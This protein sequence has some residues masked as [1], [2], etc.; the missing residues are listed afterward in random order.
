MNVLIVDDELSAIE[1]VR[2]GIQWGMIGI[3]NVFTAMNVQE[4]TRQF[5]DVPIDILLSDIEMPMGTGLE[6]L[7]W[8]NAHHPHVKCIFMT[9]HADFRF[10]QEAMQLGSVNYILKPLNFDKMQ[11]VLKETKDNILADRI[12]NEN[13]NSWIQNKKSVVKQFWKD[14]FL[15]EIS[16]NKDSLTNYFR[17]KRLEINLENAYLPI[18]IVTKKFTESVTKEDQKLLHY[19][20]RNITEEIFVIPGVAEEV[21]PFSE[22]TLLVMLEMD[23]SQDEHRLY[24]QINDCCR[25]LSDTAAKYIKEIICCY[26]GDKDTIYEMPSIIEALQERDFNNVIHES[27]VF[28]LKQERRTHSSAQSEFPIAQWREWIRQGRYNQVE[29]DITTKLTSKEQRLKINREFLNKFIRDFY[30]LI[31]GFTHDRSIFINELLGDEESNQ[32]FENALE[33]LE[34][35]LKWVNHAII[36]MRNFDKEN[37]NRDLPVEQTKK[38]IDIHLSEELSMELIAQNVHLN[39]DYLTRIFKKEVGISISKYIINKKMEVA[40]ELLIHTDRSIGEIASLV[41]YYNY[42]SFNRIFTK[43]T[44]ISPQEFKIRNRN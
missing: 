37:A 36:L 23:A 38:Y 22:T 27:E 20:L 18:L 44:G 30:Y 32:L 33:S 31:F 35:M 42:S 34:G 14:F 29:D 9:C 4:A 3:E 2:N 15:G 13:S 7:R 25:Q 43:E 11:L 12:L 1:A 17:Q 16:P 6:L 39:A 26:I 5:D 41:G 10:L 40:K 24:N 28:F 19:A 8:V 21:I